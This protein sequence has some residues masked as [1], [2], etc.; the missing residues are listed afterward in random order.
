MPAA[1]AGHRKSRLSGGRRLKSQYNPYH[2]ESKKR[3]VAKPTMTSHA[4][5]TTF[6]SLMFG[7]LDVGNAL[8][9]CATVFL[10]EPGSDSHDAKP[11]ILMPPVTV[12]SELR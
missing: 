6:V 2:T 10:P 8:R 1:A 5:W 9:P 11:G 3:A 4:R 12:P 7:S